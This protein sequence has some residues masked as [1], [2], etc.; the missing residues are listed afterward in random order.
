MGEIA[1][2]AGSG[3]DKIDLKRWQLESK[4]VVHNWLYWSEHKAK[5]SP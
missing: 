2:E 4:E 1:A 3:L 5:G